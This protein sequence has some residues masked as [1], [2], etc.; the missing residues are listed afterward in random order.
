MEALNFYQIKMAMVVNDVVQV[1]LLCATPDPDL[2]KL[3]D[4]S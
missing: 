3:V 1:L 4:I 2:K